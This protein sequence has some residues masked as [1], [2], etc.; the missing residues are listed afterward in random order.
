MTDDV[1]QARAK[2]QELQKLVGDE[3]QIVAKF[4]LRLMEFIRDK[5]HEKLGYASPW[6]FCRRGLGLC[7]STTGRRL[8]AIKVIERFP[9][10][11]AFLRDGR[12]CATRMLLLSDVLTPENAMDLFTRASRKSIKDI[13]L[14][15]A[16]ANPQPAPPTRI[17]KFPQSRQVPVPPPTLDFDTPVPTPVDVTAGPQ[18][19]P[20]DPDPVSPAVLPAPAPAPAPGTVPVPLPRARRRSEVRPTSEQEYSARFPVSRVWIGKLERAK[21]LGSHVVPTGDPVAILELA[22]DLFIEKHGKR[23]GAIAPKRPRA[24]RQV[25]E[26]VPAPEVP[27]RA[28]VKQRP[29]EESLPKREAFSAEDLRTIWERDGG[30]C[31]WLMDSGERC[32][33]D[34]QVE[35]DHAEALAKGGSSS[36]PRF[37]RLLCRRHNDQHAR[38]TFGEAFMKAKKAEAKET[39]ESRRVATGVASSSGGDVGA[40]ASP[41]PTEN[42]EPQA[43]T[44]DVFVGEQVAQSGTIELSG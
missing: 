43:R 30:K 15:V 9:A 22:L 2:S 6:D 36:D 29:A 32:G 44:T 26:I 24:G 14:L 33:S 16:A 31:V 34:W 18:P 17:R 20:P 28:P 38:E 23:R 19:S 42:R 37:G 12:L 10:V 25:P 13:E 7:E 4:L 8:K 21:K 5:M 3:L 39:R 35:V 1:V 40:A 27:V 41:D 11:V